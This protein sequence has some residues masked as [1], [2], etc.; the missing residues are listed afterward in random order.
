MTY[1]TNNIQVLRSI[2]NIPMPKNNWN[3]TM[4][5][6]MNLKIIYLHDLLKMN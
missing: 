3:I 4:T 2:F 1:K 6:T 5:T